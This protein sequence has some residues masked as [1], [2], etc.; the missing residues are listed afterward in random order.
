MAAFYRIRQSFSTKAMRIGLNYSLEFVDPY[1][2]SEEVP[3]PSD[4]LK[5]FEYTLHK[6]RLEDLVPI[7]NGVNWLIFSP[8]TCEVLSSACN[9]GDIELLPLPV[10]EPGQ[11]QCLKGYCVLG[12][13]RRIACLDLQSSDLKRNENNPEW[14]MSLYK[15]V[16]KESAVPEDLN[17]FLIKEY[18][19]F[20]V[21]RAGLA[22][23]LLALHPTGFK[24]EAIESS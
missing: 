11:S 19:V 20:P 22:Q 6:G 4:F 17:C 15:C 8:R 16:I 12:V 18:H 2:I 3:V 10:E 23:A 1:A 24:L 21:L 14:I 5:S 13:K 9:P 7:V